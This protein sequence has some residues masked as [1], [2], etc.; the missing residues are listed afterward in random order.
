[1]MVKNFSLV[2]G[3]IFLMGVFVRGGEIIVSPG[4]PIQ[5]AVDRAESGDTVTL[6]DGVY[7]EC[8]SI[9]KPITLKAA[10]GGEATISNA[11]EGTLK[12]EAV[13]EKLGLYSAEVDWPVRW[14]M[15]GDRNLYDYRYLEHLKSFT[16]LPRYSR[17]KQEA[18]GLPEGFAWENGKLYLRLW[19]DQNANKAA[20]EINSRTM[21]GRAQFLKNNG[22]KPLEHFYRPAKEPVKLTYADHIKLL[23]YPEDIGVII[24]IKADDV[25]I[26]GLRV[27]LAPHVGIDIK[28]GKNVTIRDC[29][30]DGYQYAINT[31]EK[32]ERL[33]VEYCEF[34]GGRSYELYRRMQDTIGGSLWNGYYYSNLEINTIGQKGPGFIFRHNYVYEGF[35]GIQPR[36]IAT[37]NIG[38]QP[39]I[40]SEIHH[41]V[42]M[43]FVDNSIEADGWV[44]LFNMRIH[45]NLVVNGNSMLSVAPTQRGPLQV[46]HNIF[47]NSLEQGLGGGF[48]IKHNQPNSAAAVNKGLTV[49][50]N[51]FFLPK[52]QLFWEWFECEYE[53]NVIEN[54]I[55]YTELSAP[56]DK[57]GFMPTKYN[58]LFGL[59]VSNDHLPHLIHRDPGLVSVYPID[60]RLADYSAAVA[61]GVNKDKQYHHTSI[62]DTD[63]GAIEYGENWNFP[64]PGP[65]WATPENMPQRPEWPKSIDPKQWAGL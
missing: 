14:M 9:D 39:D 4:E 30:F 53:D 37:E 13:D 54:N 52:K 23:H 43:N 26:E 55:M 22:I 46:D 42:F 51:T 63:L 25:T 50:H 62:G 49:V 65:R 40:P 1:M 45:H 56:W 20:V 36:G 5:A 35:D 7:H 10:N 16:M 27:H 21:N 24:S 57:P 15:A 64:T 28:E 47:F 2:V 17:L 48:V 32:C 60:F 38:K 11:Y 41:N 58:L 44:R 34:S 33:T 29:Y 18:T 59:R 19:G 12:F 31:W 3:F 6:R 61:A 8:I